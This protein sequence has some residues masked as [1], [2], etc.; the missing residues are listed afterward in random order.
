[1][2][3]GGLAKPGAI[4][5]HISTGKWNFVMQFPHTHKQSLT[6]NPVVSA[7]LNG[8]ARHNISDTPYPN[9]W[10]SSNT[11][12][13]QMMLW[14]TSDGIR[15]PGGNDVVTVFHS[16]FIVYSVWT[17]NLQRCSRVS[18]YELF[19]CAKKKKKIEG[20]RETLYNRGCKTYIYL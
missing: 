1:M 8:S 13:E 10:A 4:V 19:T 17:S 7:H 20:E 16:D 9:L 6:F 3:I 15:P 11:R 12:A 18:H 14:R 5:N 2:R